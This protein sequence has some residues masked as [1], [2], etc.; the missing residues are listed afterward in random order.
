[1]Q[2]GPCSEE[3]ILKEH[4]RLLEERVKELVSQNMKLVQRLT[5]AE[6]ENL[7]AELKQEDLEIAPKR[8]SID[9]DQTAQQRSKTAENERNSRS[10]Q[11]S[12]LKVPTKMD[13]FVENS[14][15]DTKNIRNL[16]PNSAKAIPQSTK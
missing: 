6:E 15:K 11:P 13:S 1:M 12:K 14:S 16:P 3:T 2:D 9:K 5:E 10:I 7:Q 4:I 8:D